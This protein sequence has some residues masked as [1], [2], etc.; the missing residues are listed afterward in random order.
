MDTQERCGDEGNGSPGSNLGTAV[1]VRRQY[2]VLAVSGDGQVGQR[3]A[4]SGGQQA[5]ALHPGA[6]PFDT[7]GIAT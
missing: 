3:E 4:F 6:Q 7:R 5:V 2:H 1:G